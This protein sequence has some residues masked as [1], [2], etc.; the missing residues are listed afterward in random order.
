MTGWPISTDLCTMTLPSNLPMNVRTT[1][2]IPQRNK[3]KRNALC[4]RAQAK[5]ALMSPPYEMETRA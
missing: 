2:K 3:T 1:E 5:A 4:I